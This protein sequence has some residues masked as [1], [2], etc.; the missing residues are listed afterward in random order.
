MTGRQKGVYAYSVKNRDRIYT[1][2][3]IA[4]IVGYHI[5]GLPCRKGL[6][7]QVC[8][9]AGK[10]AGSRER[11]VAT[12]RVRIR[13]GDIFDQQTGRTKKGWDGGLPYYEH[14][15]RYPLMMLLSRRETVIGP[16]RRR[17]AR[18]C[19]A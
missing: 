18:R 13:E 3:S 6:S 4:W 14:V 2:P 12:Y 1:L 19:F 9:E 7:G 10:Q 5:C 17:T 8:D 11:T 16:R 15:A